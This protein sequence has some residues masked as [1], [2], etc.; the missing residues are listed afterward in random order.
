MSAEPQ[1]PDGIGVAE[2]LIR[3]CTAGIERRYRERGLGLT[4]RK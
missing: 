3:R 2:T 1:V 4:L